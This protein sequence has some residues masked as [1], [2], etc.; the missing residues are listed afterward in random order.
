MSV[1]RNARPIVFSSGRLDNVGAT[2]TAIDFNMKLIDGEPISVNAGIADD[3]CARVVLAEDMD[4]ISVI[5]ENDEVKTS[6][7]E[8]TAANTKLS[9]IDSNIAALSAKI[10]TIGSKTSDNS[11]PVTLSTNEPRLFVSAS[12]FL[13]DSG[14]SRY[15]QHVRNGSNDANLKDDSNTSFSIVN[16]NSD[17]VYL[18][19]IT[20]FVNCTG[21]LRTDRWGSSGTVLTNGLDISYSDANGSDISI[22]PERIKQNMD[23]Y[24]YMT[25][26]DIMGGIWV[27]GVWDSI[28]SY[29][30]FD[31]PPRIEPGD[32]IVKIDLGD[33][34]YAS[35]NVQ[36]LYVFADF[37]ATQA[38]P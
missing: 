17:A 5:I 28:I 18:R 34:N 7:S 32:N 4:P 25:N 27:G 15:R 11:L 36:R 26:D 35:G 21:Y 23:I 19:K 2:D 33:D 14:Y 6:N 9:D 10:P 29:M 30:K 3:G 22:T 16:G 12:P 13:T 20:V 8:L 38:L 24:T 1:V 37:W 31:I